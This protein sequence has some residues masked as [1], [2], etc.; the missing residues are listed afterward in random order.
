MS[1]EQVV[2]GVEDALQ[3]LARADRL[4][5]RLTELSDGEE[6]AA[7]VLPWQAARACIARAMC[8]MIDSLEGA[9][10]VSFS[11]GEPV[12][13]AHTKEP[14]SY[15]STR[16]EILSVRCRRLAGEHEDGA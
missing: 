12:P 4:L 10:A 3:A 6:D 7:A 11:A 15:L 1:E 16:Y 14:Y 5:D 2:A 8:L 9:E 13:V